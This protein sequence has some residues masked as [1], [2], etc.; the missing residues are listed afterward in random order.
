M[1]DTDKKIDQERGDE[2]L[3]RLLKTPPKPHG[4][5]KPLTKSGQKEKG[6]GQVAKPDRRPDQKET[7]SS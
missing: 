4:D 5:K 2:V 3:R 7:T 1:S 6:D